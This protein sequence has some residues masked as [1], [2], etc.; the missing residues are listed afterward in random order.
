MIHQKAH[1]YSLMPP[2]WFWFVLAFLVGAA[3]VVRSRPAWLLRFWLGAWLLVV[4]GTLLWLDPSHFRYALVPTIAGVVLV[5]GIPSGL[6]I[7]WLHRT[8]RHR[9]L[10]RAPVQFVGGRGVLWQLDADGGGSGIRNGD[11][12]CGFGIT[13]P[14]RSSF[15]IRRSTLAD[16]LARIAGYVALLAIV[17]WM[18]AV[19]A[20][21]AARRGYGLWVTGRSVEAAAR[22][23]AS[24]AVW[25]DRMPALC[26]RGTC[27]GLPMNVSVNLPPRAARL[28]A[29]SSWIIN[30]PIVYPVRMEARAEPLDDGRAWWT[31]HTWTRGLEGPWVGV[32]IRF[33]EPGKPPRVMRFTGVR[34]E[35]AW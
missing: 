19:L 35:T 6:V 32:L 29:D 21:S 15:V 11:N 8:R 4:T 18:V 20:S 16:R 3:L 12:S 27:P 13:P 34:V 33:R 10:S 7:L 17:A 25:I 1:D 30:G 9:M 22:R 31:G 2:G 24:A 23:S 14:L 26:L 5:N 28:N